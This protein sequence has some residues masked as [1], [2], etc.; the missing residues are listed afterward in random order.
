MNRPRLVVTADDLGLSPE[1]DAGILEAA[2][3][4]IVTSVELLVNPPFRT[5]LKPILA[6]G[7]SIGLHLNLCLGVPCADHTRRSGQPSQVP[8]LVQECGAFFSDIPLLFRCLDIHE[9][10]RELDLQL[11]RFGEIVG[12]PPAHLTFHKHLHARDARLFELIA[13]LGLKHRIPVRALNEEMR[14]ALRQRGVRTS[15]AF[16]GDVTPSPYWTI[17]RLEAAL[18]VP[19]P[20]VTELMCHPGKGMATIPGVWYL[21]ER[22]TE[23]ATMVSPPAREAASRF[24]LITFSEAFAE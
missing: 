24:D 1:V 12:R 4:G 22:E 20:G 10:R 17:P 13:D 19:S 5:D 15:D 23:L 21:Q 8:S 9:A 7:V 18:Q 3:S 11:I 6:A 16:L 2:V 14:Q